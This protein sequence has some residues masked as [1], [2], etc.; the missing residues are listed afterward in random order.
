MK[1]TTTEVIAFAVFITFM[2]KYAFSK[3]SDKRLVTILIVAAIS[4]GIIV[5]QKGDVITSNNNADNA[6][7]KENMGTSSLDLRG[8]LLKRLSVLKRMRYFSEHSPGKFRDAVTKLDTF[9]KAVDRGIL[10]KKNDSYLRCE[11]QGLRDMRSDALNSLHSLHFSITNRKMRR[12]LYIVTQMSRL[13]SLRALASVV[14]KHRSQTMHLL[15]FDLAAPLS[16]N[17]NFSQ[18]TNSLLFV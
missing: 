13:E 2:T 16:S 17:N 5:Y 11:L 7:Y 8:E 3:D 12:S 18:V 14:S 6:V 10:L 4:I 15:E 1:I 9:F